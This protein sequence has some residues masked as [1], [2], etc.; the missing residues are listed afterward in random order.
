MRRLRVFAQPQAG[1]SISK[2]YL[3][4]GQAITGEDSLGLKLTVEQISHAIDANRVI[5]CRRQSKVSPAGCSGW[6]MGPIGTRERHIN[7]DLIGVQIN[8]NQ[9]KVF[10]WRTRAAER[11]EYNGCVAG[12]I[13]ASGHET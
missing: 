7:D 12:G 11:Q 13:A 9:A 8:K 6:K 10:G 1:S 3:M 5:A 2:R 4:Q